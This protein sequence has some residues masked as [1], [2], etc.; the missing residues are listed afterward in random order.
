MFNT[1]QVCPNMVLCG[2]LSTINCLRANARGGKHVLE[3]FSLLEILGF[4]T[5]V[6]N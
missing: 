5:V 1:I 3:L 6:C 2:A 4:A